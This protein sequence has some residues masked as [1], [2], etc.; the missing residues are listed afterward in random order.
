LDA[1]VDVEIGLHTLPLIKQRI[2][3]LIYPAEHRKF[4]FPTGLDVDGIT[5]KQAL[6]GSAVYRKWWQY[7]GPAVV[8]D[9]C[10]RKA[11]PVLRFNFSVHQ[12]LVL[13]YAK[14]LW[15]TEEA[16]A[17]PVSDDVL[18]IDRVVFDFPFKESG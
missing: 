14:V 17:N 16:I 18:F 7:A 9:F 5:A 6:K 2:F 4:R 8:G 15:I 12:A 13:V 1:L 10:I 3:V 11:P